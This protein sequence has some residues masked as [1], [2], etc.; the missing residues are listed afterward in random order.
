MST[1][2][3]ST[4]KKSNKQIDVVTSAEYATELT[5]ALTTE[6]LRLISRDEQKFGPDWAT[7][8]RVSV[9]ASL[10]SNVVFAVLTAKIESPA[11][12]LD[13]AASI[14]HSGYKGHKEAIEQAIA[15]GFQGAFQAFNGKSTEFFC[16]IQP[17]PEPANTLPC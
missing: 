7:G 15:A 16:Q 11:K 4:R 14:T 2:P 5:T 1:N 8:V 9:I 6:V 3:P 10:V 13:E 12:T 17:V